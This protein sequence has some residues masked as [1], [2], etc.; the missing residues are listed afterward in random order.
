M[1]FNKKLNYLFVLLIVIACIAFTKGDNERKS[2]LILNLLTNSLQQAHYKPVELNDSFANNVYNQFI[3][4][5]DYNK[6]YFAQSDIDTLLKYKW[7]IDDE[8]KNNSYSFFDLAYN[9]IDERVKETE[10]Y[11]IE[12]LSEPFDFSQEE[13]IELD[14]EKLK[15]PKNKTEIK[16]AW[17]K[18]LKYQTMIKLSD[19]V[20]I[21]EKAIEDKDTAIVIK[22]FD[23]LEVEARAKILKNY[24][25]WFVRI[26]KTDKEDRR[27]DYINSIAGI[28]DPHTAFFP[29]EDKDNFDIDISGKLEG[30][31]ATLQESEGYI[32]I[33]RIV[34]GSASHRQG[35]LK[36]GDLILNVAQEGEEAVSVVDMRLDD[37][38][39]LI[40]GPKGTKV[41]LTIKNI[42]SEI[43]DVTIERDVVNI[44]ETFARSAIISDAKNDYK[45][46]YIYLPKFYVDFENPAGRHCSKDVENEIIKLK[47]DN[48]Q[49]LIFDVRNNSGGS[50]PDA[51]DMA[52]LFIEQGPIVQVKSRFG[53]PHIMK[54]NDHRI[55][56]DGPM[57]VMIN[58]FSASASEILAAALQDYNRAIV[59]G[60]N[61][62]YGKGTVQRFIDFDAYV[63]ESANDLKPL[64]AIKLTVQ[65]FYR[66]NGGATQLKGVVPHI[67]L[68]D[69]YMYLNISEAELDNHLEW[70][71]IQ[72]ATYFKWKS[73][74]PNF[75]KITK[76]STNRVE[77]N[78]LFALAKENAKLWKERRDETNQT[79]N[80][81]KY[82]EETKSEKESMKKFDVLNE[83]KTKISVSFT[84]SDKKAMQT[85]TLMKVRYESWKDD[86]LKDFY[87]EETSAVVIDMVK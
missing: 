72:P 29:P 58:T 69:V 12:I 80:F 23:S 48:V 24:N 42:N 84:T 70:D 46:G 83:A 32:K 63:N 14:P 52:G 2:K 60:S 56:Y 26:S 1:K 75:E 64:G 37:A 86:L 13:Y 54:D 53:E 49:A 62:S 18:L 47:A 59:V 45:I 35:V 11:Y 78:E 50:L 57:A 28:Y 33:V 4:R 87:L 8:I 82:R 61:S 76:N 68:P 66:V 19:L 10:A 6:K 25:E 27:L 16:E 77:N 43:S 67:I 44:D 38:V 79:L 40:R 3:Q 71:E 73:K 51:V 20:T 34:P 31:G 36:T 7:N 17:R 15:Y 5:L 74:I 41:I 22:P 21:Q 55:H 65:K 9:I 39:K 30:I 85:D 81:N